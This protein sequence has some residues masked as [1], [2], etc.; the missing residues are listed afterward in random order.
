MSSCAYIVLFISVIWILTFAMSRVHM[1]IQA[2]S[3]FAETREDES[4]LR[5][6]CKISEFYS[7][8]KQHST[9]CDE[10]THKA[11]EIMILAAVQHVINN[12]YLCGYEAC[13]ILIDRLVFWFLG[14]GICVTISIVA[15]LVFGPVCLLPMYRRQMNQIA[16]DR[17]KFL[18]NSPFGVE[19]HIARHGASVSRIPNHEHML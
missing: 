2:Y 19:E 3:D 15:M 18:Y 10:I 1:M 6:Q 17:V 12:S 13:S 7:K 14:R 9:L 4:W 16:D 11:N 8:M 5:G